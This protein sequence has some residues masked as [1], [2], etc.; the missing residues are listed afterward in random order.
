MTAFWLR[1]GGMAA[2]EIAVHTPPL[3]ET[4]A[5]GGSAELSW[6]FNL[7]PRSPNRVLR[8]GVLVELMCGPL[9]AWSGIMGDP[10]RTTWQCTAFGLAADA[11]RY[12]ALSGGAATRDT[13]AAIA[14]ARALGWQGLN[15]S[16]I[17]GVAAGDT[18]GNPTS[19]G[20]LLDDRASEVGQRWGVDG[21]RRIFMRPDPTEPMWS[22]SPGAA[23]FGTTNE[24]SATFLA[25]RYLD[26]ST[27]IYQT[28]YVGSGAPQADVDLSERGSMTGTQATTILQQMLD[29]SRSRTAW[30]NGVEL[31][32]DQIQTMGGTP[33]FLPAVRGGQ[34]TR[35]FGLPY[36]AGVLSLDTVIGKTR[37]QIGSN[38][39]YVE[40][41]N[42]APRTL[43]DVIAAA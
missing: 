25:G 40:P 27:G 1:I 20:Q 26:S 2:S 12:L 9:P 7:T 13:A 37:H 24:D 36:S 38:T 3:M 35:A 22:V 4:W 42:T 10:D 28:V 15:F 39:I 19:L 14:N 23:A 32:R 8:P 33:A 30:T 16:G 31:T 41:V 5:D 17:S 34:L 29:T 21:M 43:T 6:E 11:R 18:T